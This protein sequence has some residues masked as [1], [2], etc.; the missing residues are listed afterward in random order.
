MDDYISKPLKYEELF[1]AINRVIIT[2]SS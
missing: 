2:P 1:E